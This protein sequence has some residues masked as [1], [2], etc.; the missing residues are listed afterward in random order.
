MDNDCMRLSATARRMRA[1]PVSVPSTKVKCALKISKSSSLA[2]SR[3][4]FSSSKTVFDPSVAWNRRRKKCRLGT[5]Q[6]F[7]FD[8]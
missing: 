3:R 6:P 2:I 7:E 1:V 5:R 4:A 8:S